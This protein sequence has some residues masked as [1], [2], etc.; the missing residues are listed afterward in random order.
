MGWN[1]FAEAW[2]SASRS[3]KAKVLLVSYEELVLKPENTLA[4]VFESIGLKDLFNAEDIVMIEEPQGPNVHEEA[5]RSRDAA[6]EKIKGKAYLNHPGT[7]PEQVTTLCEHFNLDMT[8][9]FPD[10]LDD[11]AAA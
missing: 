2:T 7:F 6:I 3:A 4:W 11:C 1:W 10:L 9:V 5:Q 8:H